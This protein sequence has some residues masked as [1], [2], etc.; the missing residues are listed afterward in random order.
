[1]NK[2]VKIIIGIIIVVLIIGL[3]AYIAQDKQKEK[4]E[5]ERALTLKQ[6]LTAEFASKKK[7]SDFIENL[8]GELIEDSIISTETLEKNTV[9]FEY[10]SIRNKKKQKSF[11]ITVVD[12]VK[13][14]IYMGSTVTVNKGYNKD[15][16]NLIFSGDN[17][18][19]TPE[20]KIIG[21]Y[22]VNTVGDYKLKFVIRDKSGNE[23]SQ[24][25]TLKVIGN[26]NGG[27]TSSNV[28]KKNLFE[29]A[30]KSYKNSNTKIGIDVSQWQGD[31]NWNKVKNAGAEFAMIRMGYQKGYD[32]ENVID[33]YFIKNIT[34]A[35]EAGV[36]V[37]I[38]YYSYAK[39]AEEAKS[40]A[41]WVAS[42]L[43]NYKI[44][45]PVSFDWE[46]WSSFVTCNMSFHDINKV[47]HTYCKT[48][49]EH[50][51][52]TSLYS[53][54]NYLEK[55]WYPEEFDNIWLA[56]YTSKTNYE[57]NY[58]M[59]QFCNTGKIDGINGDVDID[60]LYINK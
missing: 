41:E 1:M 8:E 6:N 54:K 33:P 14:M 55:I 23:A 45:L 42:N 53:S 43:K 22:D 59:W 30:I 26:S 44:D 35:K 32:G 60:V 13:P 34:G 51:Y 31:I 21:D 7:L 52:Q 9:S 16:V 40:Q 20:R 58:H 39:T 50:G 47:A 11:E 12:T 5:D 37:G 56:H 10:K 25:F 36:K 19:S 24:N 4:K 57:G 29:D 18:D 15:I 3:A 48:L 46:S 27:G 2:F 38:Y 49:K 28:Q 17:C